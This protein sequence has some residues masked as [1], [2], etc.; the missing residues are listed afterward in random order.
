MK[1]LEIS[2]EHS[3]GIIQEGRKKEK[4]SG[5]SQKLY[6]IFIGQLIIEE[7]TNRVFFWNKNVNKLLVFQKL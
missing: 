6:E 3:I 1:F 5:P 4:N 7:E 2:T